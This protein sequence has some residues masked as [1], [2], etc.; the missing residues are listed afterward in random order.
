MKT[1]RWLIDSSPAEGRKSSLSPDICLL[2]HDM[3]IRNRWALL[4]R[5]PTYTAENGAE[6]V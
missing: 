6:T 5:S 3:R 1:D 2:I 4:R